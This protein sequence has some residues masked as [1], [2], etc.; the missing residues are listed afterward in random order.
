MDEFELVEYLWYMYDECIYL[1]YVLFGKSKIKHNTKKKKRKHLYAKE[2]CLHEGVSF[3]LF[4]SE[5]S[6]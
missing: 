5:Y 1:F 6:H 3:E 2:K 4:R